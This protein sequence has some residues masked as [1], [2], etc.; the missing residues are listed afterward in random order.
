MA[1]NAPPSFGRKI[2]SLREPP[3][4]EQET[5]TTT[6]GASMQAHIC[7]HVGMP[8]QLTIRGVPDEVAERLAKLSAERGSSVNALVVELLA[9][10]VDYRERRQR[11]KRYTT[12]TDDDLTEF[13]EALDAQ[14]VIDD[15]LWN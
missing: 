11:L 3:R 13:S 9:S 10:A 4:P 7:Y 2:T 6:F 14:R 15:E 5:V 12:W 8:K 1:P